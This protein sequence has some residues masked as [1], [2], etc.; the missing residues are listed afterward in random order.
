[1]KKYLTKILLFFLFIVALLVINKLRYSYYYAVPEYQIKLKDFEEKIHKGESFNTVLWGSS[2]IYRQL[3]PLLFDN[4]NLHN[5]LKTSTYNFGVQGCFSLEQLYLLEHFL[6]NSSSSNVKNVLV[7]LQL[8][9]K[10]SSENTLSKRGHYFV[11][12]K[13]ITQL[14]KIRAFSNFKL[15]LS[16]I[17][18]GFLNLLNYQS[19]IYFKAK[20]NSFEIEHSLKN[21]GYLSLNEQTRLYKKS[22]YLEKRRKAFT[23]NPQKT[24]NKSKQKAI[25]VIDGLVENYLDILKNLSNKFKNVNFYVLCHPLSFAL[26]DENFENVKILCLKDKARLDLIEE[27]NNYFDTGHLSED[28]AY[29][30]TINI[31]E[32]YLNSISKNKFEL[33]PKVTRRVKNKY[34]PKLKKAIGLNQNQLD[35]I[36][37]I[38]NSYAQ[39]ISKIP[40]SEKERIRKLN[41]EKQ[42]KLKTFLGKTLYNKKVSFDQNL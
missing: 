34:Y 36:K 42:G 10:I 17:K 40:K 4:I 9:Y 26:E 24:I 6:S 15:V 16:Y 30:F 29:N 1:M 23:D 18:S 27:T 38:N 28:G 39:K 35:F 32:L 11:N 19:S 20:N 25:K 8:P 7:E 13:T 2:H 21:S 22:N 33:P 37:S 14:L 41:W 12:L 5:S 31:S 3:D